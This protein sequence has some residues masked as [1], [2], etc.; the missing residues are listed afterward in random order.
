[1][2]T[3]GYFTCPGFWTVTPPPPPSLHLPGTLEPE[4]Q[5]GRSP[6]TRSAL[7]CSGVTLSRSQG[8]TG[9]PGGDAAGTSADSASPTDAGPPGQPD[10]PEFEL[11]SVTEDDLPAVET[12]TTLNVSP[13]DSLSVD[14]QSQKLPANGEDA[15]REA[16]PSAGMPVIKVQPFMP[17]DDFDKSWKAR[18]SSH[19]R[20]LLA[21]LCTV[22]ALTLV[23]GV[24]LGVGLSCVGRFRCSSSKCIRSSSQCDGRIDCDNGEDELG[25][26]RLSGRSSV[27]QVQ[28][29]GVWMTVCSEGWNNWLGDSACRQLGYSSYVESFY[30]PLTSIEQNLQ[31]SLISVNLSQS[32]IIKLQNATATSRV[33]CSSGKV[34]TLKCLDCGR[35]PRFHT[36]IVGG[37]ISSP[38]QFPWQVSLHFSAEHLCGGSIVTSRWIVTAAHCVYGFSDPAMWAVHVGVTEQP[39]HG[40][41]SVAVERIIYHSK[42]RPKGLDYDVALMKLSTPLQFNVR[43]SGRSSVL[44]VCRGRSLDDGLFRGWNN[45]LGDSA[46]R[47]LGYSSYVESFYV[48]LTS[49]EQ[50]LQDSLISVNLS[51]S[52]IIKLQNATA[53][54]RVECSSGKVTTLKCLDCGRRRPRFHTRIVGGNI[55]SPGQFPWQVSLHFSAEHLCGGSIVTSA[56]SLLRRTASTG[57]SVWGVFSDPAMWAVHVGVTEQPVHGAQSVAVERIIYHS[58]YRPKGLDYDVALMKLSTPLQ[59]NGLVEPICLPNHNEEFQPGTMCWISGWGATEEEGETSV[60]QRSAMVPLLSTKTCNQPEVYQGFISSWM[61]CAGYLEGGTDS[62]QGDSGGPLACEDSS[63]WKL[64]GATSWG[65]G[66]AARNKPGVYTRITQALGWIRHQ[67]ERGDS[68]SS[69]RTM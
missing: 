43:L 2:E 19:W 1:M 26:V 27:L 10:P 24:G 53:T 62:C 16:A 66:C 23:L 46:C 7:T 28:R 20:P 12:P 50:N 63:G 67:M 32:Q 31:D 35:R 68:N 39:V 38:G 49:I 41:Q 64:V 47:Q 52:Q 69:A 44:Q 5:R 40:A 33:E 61:V 22:L 21:A 51:Q 60:V 8:T 34:T 37:N 29:G 45:W 3:A 9:P 25:C 65:I 15:R 59:F 30:V 57:E 11:V 14:S 56:G 13:L 6:D 58:K 55:S 18:L 36:R 4:L 42:Y 17:D 54:S 48:P